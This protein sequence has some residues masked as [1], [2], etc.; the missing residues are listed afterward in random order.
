MY[1]KPFDLL[2][3]AVETERMELGISVSVNSLH[4]DHRHSFTRSFS[5]M[6]LQKPLHSALSH[7]VIGKN[8]HEPG[9][10]MTPG[11]GSHLYVV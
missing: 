10:W 9:R 11:V 5:V 2:H 3:S 1:T 6:G 4:A 7:S 8:R